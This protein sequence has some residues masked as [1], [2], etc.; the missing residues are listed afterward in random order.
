MKIDFNQSMSMV[1][2]MIKLADK[3]ILDKQLVRK[4]LLL[5]AKYATDENLLKAAAAT[6]KCL[7]KISKRLYSKSIID[8]L[9]K[10]MVLLKKERF[11]VSAEREANLWLCTAMDK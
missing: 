11:H 6:Q 9:K 10:L 4:Q 7:Q 1:K 5:I 2:R 8:D 3:N